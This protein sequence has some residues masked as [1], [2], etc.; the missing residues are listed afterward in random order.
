MHYLYN[1]MCYTNRKMSTESEQDSRGPLPAVVFC[2]RAPAKAVHVAPQV[3]VR[4][5]S[6]GRSVRTKIYEHVVPFPLDVQRPL[7]ILRVGGRVL[8]VVLDELKRLRL[9]GLLDVLALV[10][11]HDEAKSV[12]DGEVLVR[13]MQRRR[14]LTAKHGGGDVRIGHVHA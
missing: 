2:A 5:V 3:L 4:P 12:L 1:C 11:F 13:K 10:D 8:R 14:S 6:S 9:R 7:G